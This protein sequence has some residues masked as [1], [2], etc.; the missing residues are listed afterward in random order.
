MGAHPAR[1]PN[2]LPRVVALQAPDDAGYNGIDGSGLT[3]K[4]GWAGSSSFNVADGRI[5]STMRRNSFVTATMPMSNTVRLGSPGLLGGGSY[6]AWQVDPD[7]VSTGSYGF[8][9]HYENHA[10]VPRYLAACAYFMSSED[11][12]ETWKDLL[13]SSDA[14]YLTYP[15]TAQSAGTST[16]ISTGGLLGEDGNPGSLNPDSLYAVF[17]TIGV[18]AAEGEEPD[19]PALDIISEL[20]LGQTDLRP[21]D[22]LA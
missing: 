16:T 22:E 4:S 17:C 12:G 5:V 21:S 15:L 14:F 2:L 13:V 3:V 18:S 20:W 1:G 10:Q 8:R 6:W 9:F 11:G 7:L 19:L